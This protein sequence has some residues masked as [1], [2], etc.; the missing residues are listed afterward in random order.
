MLSSKLH[1]LD[2]FYNALN[3]NDQGA[4]D[5]A[6][7]GNFLDKIPRECLSIIESK[8]KI[9]ASLEDKLDIR[10]NRFKKSL[11][12]MP[13]EPL[14]AVTKNTVTNSKFEAHTTT[15]DANIN[16]LHL[17]IDAFQKK[18]KQKHDDFQ[19]QMMNF[20]SGMSY[21]EPPIPPSGVKQQE[22][23]EA[24][25]DTELPSPEDIQPPSV[26]VEVQKLRE[27]DDILA[28]KF[29]EIF[30]D[31]H[32]ELSFANA[33]VHM[34]KF[35]LM[36]KKLLNNKAK[37]I[38]LTNTPLN[39]NC[40]AVV[41]KKLPEKLGDP[42]RFLIP[43][44]FLEFDNCLALADLG[45][46][47]NLMLLSI[48]KK[49]SLP[50]LNDTKMVLELADRTISKPTGIAE[51][52]FVKVGQ[53]YFPADFVVLDFIADP[54]V[55][56]ILGR[57]FLSTA[58]A[59][60]DVYEGE[61][62]LRHDDQ[63]LTL[64]CGD[65][66]S[67]SYN[68]FKSLNNVDLIDATCDEYSQEVLGFADVVSDE[69]S[70]PYFE[71][72]VS[73]SSQNLTPFN[74]SDFLLMEEADAFI[75]IDDESIST[76][77]DATY[78]DLEGDILILEALLNNNPEPP[79]SNQKDYFPSIQKDLKVVEPKNQSSD[80]ELPK[81]ELKDLPPHLEYAFLGKNEKW[82]V[83]ISKDLSVNEKSALINVLKSRKKVIAWKLTDIKGIDPEFC[84]YKIL[85]ED[86]FSPKVQ[87]QR[88]VNPKIHDAGLIYP[89][90]DSPWVSPIHCVPKKGGMTVITNNENELV[91]TR[92]VTGWRVC[93]DYRKL[94]EA[95]RKDHFPLPFMDQ[96]LERLAWNEYY[97]FLD[98]FSG[99]FQIPIDSKDQEK[100]TFTCPYGTFAYK[101]MSFGLC[102]APGTFQ[103]C[104]MAIF[105]DM[106]EQTMEVFMDDFSVFRNSFSTCLTNL[107]KMLKCK[108]MTQVETN[109]TTTEK[110]MLAV[111]YAFE[112]FCSY[113][114]MNKSIVYTDH[115]A[116]KY[117]FAK[118]DAKARLLR[119]ILL[120]QDFDF[121]VI[122]TKGAENYAADHLLRLENPY[123]NVFDPKEIN[124][125]FPLE[126]LNKVA[127]QD[128]ST[129][130]G[131]TGEHC[132]A[133][134]TTKKVF[135]SGFYWP[136][137]YKD[138]FEL[139]KHCD[140]YQRQGKISQK[141][142][143]PQNSIQVCEIF[144]VWVID[145][146]GPFPSSK[147][148]KYI[149][150]AVDYL[151]KWVEAK[152]L[153]T[154]DARVIVKILKSLFFWFGTPKA[155]ISDRG[156]HFCNDQFSRV[157]S[158]YEVTHRLSTAY[159]PQTSGQVEVTNHGLKRI[160][161][162]TMGENHTLWSDKLEDAL[163]AFKTAF[164][165]PV[166][167]TP[168]RGKEP[169]EQALYSKVSLKER[170]K[171]FLHGKE[172]GRDIVIF[173]VVV[174]VV[175][176]AGAEDEEEKMS[177][178]K[179][180][181]NGLLIEEVVGEA[182]NIKE[183]RIK[184]WHI[185]SAAINHMTGEEYLFVEMKQSKDVYNIPNLKSIIL[186]V[187]QLLEKNYDIHFKDC[188]ATIR[189][190]EGKL[191]AKVPLTKNRMFI[192]NIQ[193][194][195]AKCLKSCLEDHSWLWHMR[196]GHLNFND[197]KLLSSK[198]M[199]KGLDHIDHPNQVCKGCLFGKHARSL[200]SKE[201]TSR[202]KE[203][204]QLI[205]I[206]L[207]GPISPSSHAF[208]AFKTFKAIVEKE[209]SLKI[210]SMRSDRG[211]EFLPKEFNKFCEDNG[212]RRFLTA[213]Y[214]LQQNGVVER[215]NSYILN[216][217]QSMLKTKKMPKEFWVE[218]VDCAVCLLNRC[219]SK[220]LDNKTPQES[221]NGLKP[222]V[223]HLR[224]FG[225]IAYV[226]LPSRRRL[227]LDDRSE[228]HVLTKDNYGSWCIR[229]KALLGSHDVWEIVEK[230]IEKVDDES[231]LNAT[232]RVDL[233]K[234][235]NKDQSALTLIYQC[236]DDAMFEKVVNAT[237]SKE[238]WEI[239]QNTFKGIDKVKN[240]RLQTLRGE[241][242]KLQMEEF[243]TIS[244]Y[245]TCALTISNKMKRNGE[246]LS[247]TRVIEKILRSLPPSFDYIVVAIEESKDIDSMTID[248]LM[249]SL[250]AHEEKLMK[251]REKNPWSKL[252]T[253]RPGRGRGR[254]DVIK[255]DENQWPSYRRGH[256]RGFQ[257]QRG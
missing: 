90:S 161:K 86:D 102:N 114:I 136:T 247:D 241:F 254:E 36:F 205:H 48:W 11:N 236:L 232:Q 172:Q 5:F 43:Y 74:E 137:I 79:P 110:E 146:K 57:P 83:I 233:Q 197:L 203:P 37:L 158:K 109:Y 94:N 230:G 96:M 201:A 1:Q 38:E 121:K 255:E 116:L 176:K 34:P 214:S 208:E 29:L 141:D 238:A 237:T 112:K 13:T 88:R 28:A 242:E 148:N 204:L 119:W 70:T 89:I 209:K 202:A 9:V 85:L 21:K 186:R 179:M 231:L 212:I 160:L 3:P 178:K 177:S 14:K 191:I 216:M 143:M 227:K 54:R 217:V 42:G 213:P 55:P 71:P 103:R 206:D 130:C 134:Y 60:I 76:K 124:E 6:A 97:C 51:N 184:P 246:S 126:T 4:I 219:L 173:V 120:L 142:E 17:K 99:Y 133:N 239:F 257:Y 118:K 69:V 45:A 82:P 58:H 75:A 196:Y 250:Q 200:F 166:G 171:S 223:S 154:N 128:K 147:G 159:H 252:Y 10:M 111:V 245:F 12:D 64:K 183:E 175:S 81:V 15:N 253:Q 243:K 59:L 25:T 50:T 95:T 18:F 53:F 91:P 19:N 222:T 221:W 138:A 31:L 195:E 170:E 240:V 63:S 210:K 49:L 226:H 218:A 78:Y 153:P 7:G 20:M 73:N 67:I 2:T 44:D 192:L 52:V 72:I 180:R 39:E 235:R 193:H 101:R 40:S 149:L 123:E 129:P 194:D 220:S 140:S 248:Q 185:D 16:N 77:I 256:G 169:L 167:C 224:V 188:S 108:T 249:G 145:F 122:D 87:S 65:T 151:S 198:G 152:A 93:I 215:K 182:F 117:L 234:E 32:F 135:D 47:I 8:S 225:S 35:S 127:H 115:S 98:G 113:L 30:R 165:T 168:Y 33:L 84:S 100:T 22:P 107:E 174:V 251:R 199:V 66:P 190:Q 41:L 27:K 80:D 56:L 207:Y 229:M 104:M 164:K 150:V 144:D 68:N 125:T 62:T 132:E 106:I 139:V 46:S 61:I 26:Q 187:G 131:P 228:K 189:I 105:H 156:T 24:T 23:T 162:R 211:G 157:M 163:W 155:I 244:D 181:T 92:L